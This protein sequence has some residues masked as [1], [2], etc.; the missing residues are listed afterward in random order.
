MM[1]EIRSGRQKSYAG[2]ASISNTKNTEKIRK[3]GRAADIA[4]IVCAGIC[5]LSLCV[6]TGKGDASSKDAVYQ[7]VGSK[8]LGA[9]TY[10]PPQQPEEWSFWEY[11]ADVMAG[12]FGYNG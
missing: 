8:N 6:F 2:G 12:V 5:A 11:F 9:I 10:T 4:A 1:R 3:K 7:A